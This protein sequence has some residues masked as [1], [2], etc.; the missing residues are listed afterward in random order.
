[1]NFRRAFQQW[2]DHHEVKK[3]RGRGSWRYGKAAFTCIRRNTIS[4]N[5][6][7]AKIPTLL[8]L[9]LE[10]ISALGR[11]SSFLPP[12]VSS[13]SVNLAWS[14][15]PSLWKASVL[16]L[17]TLVSAMTCPWTGTLGPWLGRI[18]TALL[19]FQLGV[20]VRAEVPDSRWCWFGVAVSCPWWSVVEGGIRIKKLDVKIQ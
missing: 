14:L 13:G 5:Q 10:A 4:I 3:S 16:A 9:V 11:W 2:D 12:L 6:G 1:M 18:S 17:T 20:K 7:A 8:V 19:S 15:P